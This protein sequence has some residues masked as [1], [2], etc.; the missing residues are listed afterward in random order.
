VATR[1]ARTDGPV[2]F[3]AS[4]L[5]PV[6]DGLEAESAL[7]A[8][9]ECG[10]TVAQTGSWDWHLDTNQ[11]RWSDN[12]YRIFGLEPGEI[13]PT[14]GYVIERA[15]PYDRARV[16]RQVGSKR[17]RR[18]GPLEYRIVRPDG[19][20]RHLRASEAIVEQVG[21]RPRRIVGSVQDITD[22]HRA[23][24]AIA[25]HLA[26]AE[27]LTDWQ[28]F[29]QGATGLLRNLAVAL[30]CV[31]GVMWLPDGDVLVAHVI[32]RSGT[33][34]ITEL[35]SVIRQLRLPRGVGL[36]GQVWGS[37]EP[38][39]VLSLQDDPRFPA[40]AVAG[41]RGAVALPAI[42]AQD[43]LAVLEFCCEPV[44]VDVTEPLLRSLTSIGYELGEFLAHR[45]GELKPL[46]LTPRELQVL[47]LAAQGCAGREIARR[48]VV[49]PATVRTHFE[50]IYEKYGVSD[51]AAAVAKALRDGLIE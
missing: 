21:G 37:G 49:S 34:D 45:R 50:R 24:R 8:L 10:E 36:A 44:S 14:Q 25:A 19:V 22:W 15:H 30:D 11:L 35:E 27:A 2:P 5:E 29:E 46:S 47:Q 7:Q 20:V 41:L 39:N 32:W 9:L 12:L 26:V 1:A 28:T 33:T 3:V 48:L 13:T 51:R 23:E 40:E 6:D 42:H 16:E 4:I 17:M 38:R 43:V 31:A 18:V